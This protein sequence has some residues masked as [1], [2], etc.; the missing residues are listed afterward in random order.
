M[1][2]IL[3]PQRK[4]L[5]LKPAIR[6]QEYPVV[7]KAWEFGAAQYAASTALGFRGSRAVPQSNF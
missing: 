1:C 6:A 3:M 4:I 7:E 2:E 5:P